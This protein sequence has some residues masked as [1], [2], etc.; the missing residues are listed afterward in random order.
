M[1]TSTTVSQLV[2]RVAL[3]CIIAFAFIANTNAQITVTGSNGLNATYT[4]FTK[5]GGLFAALNGGASQ[6]GMN[7][8]V[9]ITAD[10]TTEDSTNALNAGA[11]TSITITP[12]G[13]RTISGAVAGSLIRYNGAD[14]VTINGL[15]SGGNALTISNT[16]AAASGVFRLYNDAS[17]NTITNCTITG[18][19]NVVTS[20]IIWFGTGVTTGNDGNTVSNNSITAAGTNYPA[21]GI[22]ST[23]T[24]TSVDN[25]GNTISGNNIF[26][27]FSATVATN[28]ILINATGNNTWTIS[29]NKI[30]QTASRTFTTGNTHSGIN[31]LG[32]DGYSVSNN[33]IGY[34]SSSA[35]GTYT[36]LGSVAT[37][38]TGINL[39]VGTTTA[40]SVQGNTI[41][42]FNITSAN[43]S[44]T[45][46]PSFS[47][48]FI[49]AGNV[50]LGTTTGNTIGSNSSAHSVVV[51]TT[52][53]SGGIVGIYC[54]STGTININSTTMGGLTDTSA[55]AS[56]V[57]GIY[58]IYIGSATTSLTISNCTLGNTV[59]N[60]IIA[61]RLGFTTGA[62]NVAGIAAPSTPASLNYNNN[63]IQ[64]L[65]GYGATTSGFTKGIY[66]TT[67]GTTTAATIYNNTIRNLL[68]YSALT[69]YTSALNACTGIQFAAGLN[70]TIYGNTINGLNYGGTATTNVVV[71]GIALAA[72][73]QTKVYRNRIYD[74]RNNGKSNISTT[75]NV[76]VGIM[77]RGGT[78]NDSI[79][80]NMISLGNGDT[81]NAAFTGIMLQMGSSACNSYIYYNTINIEGTVSNSNGAMLTAAF[82]HGDYATTIR[83]A[84]VVDI[85]NNIF[86]N[87]RSGGLGKHYA[88]GNN[89]NV[90][91]G[92]IATVWASNNNLLYASNSSNIGYWLADKNFSG[93]KTS[94]SGDAN[95]TSNNL[96]TYTNSANDLHINMGTSVQTLESQ[97]TSIST[98]TTDFDGDPRPG[99]TVSNNG[100]GVFP[101]VG[102]DEFDGTITYSCDPAAAP[103]SVVP[104]PAS[105]SCN[106]STVLL[107]LGT[108]IST[109]GN[110]YQWQYSTNGTTG[111]TNISGATNDNYTATIA[112]LNNYYRCGITCA[113]GG[114]AV[115]STSSANITGVAPLAAGTY[116]I[117]S[118]A[119]TGGSNYNTFTDA[120][121]DLNCK[122]IAGAVV[123]NVSGGPFV[124][125]VTLNA[126][127]GSSATNTIT[128]NGNG[129]TLSFSSST[130]T[131]RAG[132]TLNG[133]DYVTIDNLVIDASAGTYGWGI[134]FINGADYNT[135]SNCNIT[136][137]TISTTSTNCAAIM[138]SASASGLTAGT[139]GS[140]NNITGNTLKRWLLCCLFILW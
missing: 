39:T 2:K 95:S 136:T 41:A 94:A 31:I 69:S 33:T 62:C 72:A 50:N 64:N 59:A 11:W 27:I 113:N 56:N 63:T 120:F 126:V 17:N 101:D 7:I 46:T 98:I 6:S 66:T 1:K 47:G 23:G 57:L 89:I 93:W 103:N 133:A 127:A 129:R 140:N 4:S 54:G 88:I 125:Q 109:T 123:F 52:A 114:G 26:N 118:G 96:Y 53:S 108:A 139:T 36:M 15:N 16:N 40:T 73:S 75:P 105:V 91:S 70:A 34:A 84:P 78:T 43:S 74:I 102:A 97:G 131:A 137:S 45:T 121:T 104:T 130:S 81:T 21:N 82:L 13:V 42:N 134:H 12:S 48:V 132:I 67:S 76:A 79:Y 25:S 128:I 24:S 38:F 119:A 85:R 110:T 30:Y 68:T 22:L 18:S 60:N 65:T 111:W 138:F 55:T 5:S 116:T 77:V 37:R 117:N 29:S 28:A 8:T 9:S 106:G 124:E 49:N 92:T 115:Y 86:T 14:N 19:G 51:N 32:G 58:C 71:S 90:T 3:S 83:L 107:T 10:V 44:S 122:G 35:T 112:A 87:T 20:G 99:P 80:N 100:G 61:G 135:I